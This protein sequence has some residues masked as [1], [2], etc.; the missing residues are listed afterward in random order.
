M[1][2]ITMLVVLLGAVG[3][4]LLSGGCNGGSGGGLVVDP[5]NFTL[6]INNPFFPLVPGTTFIY[7]GTKDGEAARDEFAV[8]NRTKVIQGVTCRE[9][10]DKAFVA[11]V[12]EETTLD[13]FA[14][15]KAGNVWY[16]G[17]DTKE[18]DDNGNVVST[19]GSFE[20]G[21]SGAQA[22]IVMKANPTVGET[23]FQERA[24][25]VAE[26]QATVLSLN[27]TANVPFGNFTNCLK[28]KEF[29]RLSPGAV[30]EK[31]Y[32]RG[33]GFVLSNKV[34]GGSEQVKLKQIINP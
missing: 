6:L 16:F 24:K 20:A 14:Q 17:E 31:F 32:A 3:T 11:G 13:W 2:R 19:E 34:Q 33:V 8:T 10:T 29:T 25:N 9:V 18:L 12:L 27:A 26:D 4:A 23:Y 7:E 5:A 1:K 21:V 22:G 30:E 15:D 28:T